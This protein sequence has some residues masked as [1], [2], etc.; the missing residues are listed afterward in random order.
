MLTRL[1]FC[2]NDLTA[3]F[4]SLLLQ[5]N[6]TKS[7]FTWFFFFFFFFIN[8]WLT[9]DSADVVRDLNSELTMK[10]HISKIASSCF[11]HLRRLRQLLD[12]VS[13]ETMK[14]LVTS[15]VLSRIDYC[16]VVLVGLPASTIALLQR[17]QNAAVHVVLCLD[18]RSHIASAL[19]NDTET[20]A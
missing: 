3:L 10:H 15:L 14:Q 6:A 20:N 5:R 1:S 8:L 2:I 16:D 17:L 13:Q 7:E 11:Y 9:I 4:F 19:G 18:C 12:K